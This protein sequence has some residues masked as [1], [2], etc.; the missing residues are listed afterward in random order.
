MSVDNSDLEKINSKLNKAKQL[1]NLSN[2]EFQ[3]VKL[4]IN[5]MINN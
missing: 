5:E 2:D 3:G 1:L 4:A